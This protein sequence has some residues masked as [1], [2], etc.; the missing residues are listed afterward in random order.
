MENELISVFGRVVVFQKCNVRYVYICA[1][2]LTLTE[3]AQR[4]FAFDPFSTIDT[5][6]VPTLFSATSFQKG[7]LVVSS[8]RPAAILKAERTLGTRLNRA[9]ESTPSRSAIEFSKT[10]KALGRHTVFH[11]VTERHYF[12]WWR[13]RGLGRKHRTTESKIRRVICWHHIN[14]RSSQWKYMPVDSFSVD[15]CNVPERRC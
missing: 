8:P 4:S 7:G 10:Q 15:I 5:N 3:L 13:K 12:Y 1:R 2:F 14:Y 6:L 9:V 11:N